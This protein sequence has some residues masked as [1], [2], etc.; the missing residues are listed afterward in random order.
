MNEGI[1]AFIKQ[2]LPHGMCQYSARRHAFLRQG[3][4]NQ[5]A[6]WIALSSSR[7]EAF[8]DARL[9][10][11]PRTITAR[12][13]T[14][15]DAGAHVGAW[16]SCLL[17]L[18]KPER[19]L[20]LECEPRLVETLQKRFRDVPQVTVMDVALSAG[21]GTASFHRLQHPASS[22]LLRPRPEISKEFQRK[23]EVKEEIQVQTIGYDELV[24]SER[25]V[26]ILKLDIQGA[27][28]MVL[29]HA[30][31]GLKK[32]LSLITEVNFTPHYN[33]EGG[34]AEIH[35]LL[36]QKGFGLYRLSQPYHRGGRALFADFA[37]VRENLLQG[38]SWRP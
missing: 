36:V 23:W 1:K 6:S 27:E 14:C 32:T 15:V 9:D 25:E 34:F 37:Y 10:L 29:T 24:K 13:R 3:F 8:C 19:V 26:S 11:L 22:S 28:K 35:Q 2:F 4:C 33:D 12:L 20:A 5:D 7:Y 31:E 21:R 38:E 18:F 30:E 16:T 17:D